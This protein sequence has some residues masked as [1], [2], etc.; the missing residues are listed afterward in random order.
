MI[1]VENKIQ[2]GTLSQ[3]S[4]PVSADEFSRMMDAV[5]YFETSPAV[6]VGVSGGADSLS[7]AILT[8]EWA[9]AR[10]GKVIALTV[11]HGLRTDSSK[12]ATWV[13]DQ[14][15]KSD[16][17]HHTLIWGGEKP[18]AGIQEKA[19]IARRDLMLNWCRDNGVLHLALGHHVDDQV[20]THLMRLS[21]G[22]TAVGLAAMALVRECA[23]ARIVR[24]MLSVTKSRLEA[25]LKSREQDW[26]RDPSNEMEHFERVRVRR[27]SCAL[28]EISGGLTAL[29]NGIHDY[30]E[31]RRDLEHLGARALAASVA[32]YPAGYAELKPHSLEQFG[33][34]PARYALS[35][36]LMAVGGRR[37][38]MAR[39][40]LARGHDFLN[41]CQSG[42]KLTLG[43]CLL[44][45]NRNEILVT[46]EDRNLPGHQP[47]L[48]GSS[49]HWDNR[50]RLSF[51]RHDANKGQGVAFGALGHRG[52][53]QF[54]Q[55][56]PELRDHSV[57]LSARY[58][59]P[60]LFHNDE[61]IAV[62]HLTKHH[63]ADHL[64]DIGF[65][66]AAFMPCEPVLGGM[67]SVALT[68]LCTI[69]G[70]H[71]HVPAADERIDA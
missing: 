20:E 43:G 2:Q 67:F 34:T 68:G 15:R 8:Q 29:V 46:R 65:E 56:K 52:W 69:S 55:M 53:E 49:V 32:L 25:T 64:H 14:M 10:G 45:R 40:K 27:A 22:S 62:S 28:Q 17:E 11:D 4:A 66:K 23:A 38:P 26:V 24:P 70:E 3:T 36:L 5:G 21:R 9:T 31:V 18:E 48:P 30:G 7:L 42:D 57:P 54:V 71:K 33:E 47:V 50:F 41:G 39:E 37:Y 6:A 16:I 12:E 63:A 44:T 1:V 13:S 19:R 61:I 59:L 51:T 58:A 60:T 35:R